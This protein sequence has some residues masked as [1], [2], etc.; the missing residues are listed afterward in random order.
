MGKKGFGGKIAAVSSWLF[1][2]PTISSTFWLPMWVALSIVFPTIFHFPETPS[3]IRVPWIPQWFFRIL[4]ITWLPLTLIPG[5]EWTTEFLYL[6]VIW[7][8]SFACLVL[9]LVRPWILLGGLFLFL[10]SLIQLLWSKY[11]K[12]GLVTWGFYSLVRHPQYLGIFIWIFGHILYSLPFH[13]RPADLL[14]WV[15][16]IFLYVVMARNEEKNL[17]SRFGWKY[18]EYRRKTP[19]MIPFIPICLSKRLNRIHDLKE[20]DKFLITVFGYLAA[21]LLILGLTYGRTYLYWDKAI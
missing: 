11:K 19:F 18:E 4:Y 10:G 5:F 7:R 15:S 2:L 8:N 1:T 20:R 6:P 13:L 16:L 21:V 12:A 14:A 17:K 9:D 3:P